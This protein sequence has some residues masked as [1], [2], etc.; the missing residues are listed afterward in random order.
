MKLL[1]ILLAGSFMTVG[2]HAAT[3]SGGSFT[4]PLQT[5][6]I[7]QTGNLSLFNSTLGTLTGVSLTFTG[8]NVTTITLKNNATQSQTTKATSTTDLFFGSSI[9]AL[10]GLI[11]SSNPLVSLSETTGF[12]T[13]ASGASQAFGPL[14]DGQSTIWTS[15]LSGILSSF[16]GS[17]NFSLS[18][19]S[20][21]G[22]AIS[23]GGGNISSTQATQAGCGAALT[24]TYTPTVV[25]VP[26]PASL[27]LVG[28]A[29]IGLALSTRKRKNVA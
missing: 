4:N 23:G 25:T 10:N 14:S 11:S 29:L 15:Q 18:C 21:S 6:E 3:I 9:A 5:T 16:V 8:A 26:E 12:V 22:I 7:S 1:N 13:L 17:G 20:I 2:A 19:N 27:A 24:Y 28:A